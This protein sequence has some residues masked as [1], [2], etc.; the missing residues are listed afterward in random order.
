MVRIVALSLAVLVLAIMAGCGG[1][2]DEATPPANNQTGV[3]TGSVDLNSGSP[4]N[5]RL[6]LNGTELPVGVNPDGT[7]RIPNIPPGEHVLD[8]IGPDGTEAGRSEFE[9]EPGEVII[10][11]PI[12]PL[13][14]GQI[15]GLVI[16]NENG[17]WVPAVG[18]E[19]VARSDLLW[20][21]D[22]EGK[23]TIAPD[24]TSADSS[25]NAGGANTAPA[26]PFIYP[27]PPGVSYSAITDDTG[28]FVMRAVQE[29]PY[30]VTV[31]VPGYL[32]GEAFV[33]VSPGQTA[34]ADF[35]LWPEKDPETG[36]I[37]GKVMGVKLDGTRAPIAGASIEVRMD[38][39]WFLPPP[40]PI[41]LP[42]DIRP[43]LPVAGGADATDPGGCIG[44]KP[45]IIDWR[46]FSTV[47]DENGEYSIE[48]P[49][50]VRVV[51][52]WAWPYEWAEQRV[53]VPLN[54]VVRAD[55]E[56]KELDFEE[57]PIEPLPIFD[58]PRK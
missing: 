49:A 48:V 26:V 21:M 55:F 14:A 39:P 41:E 45:P 30:F 27:P 44:I 57:P 58:R 46:V 11:P 6:L 7:F 56:L 20:I 3:L 29:G 18:V 52:A 4:E 16:K 23:P 53:V 25:P 54:G 34:V 37:V 28:S 47:T 8:I 42:P 38:Q 31:A 35:Q 13:P 50:G 2:G 10:L 1:G 19:V 22:D 51:S 33:Y 9:I 5:C 32:T 36:K 12:R 15:A 40:E 24:G 17:V 43:D